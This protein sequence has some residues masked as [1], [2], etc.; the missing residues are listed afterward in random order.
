ML[1]LIIC[2]GYFSKLEP[3][4]LCL[5]R[6]KVF[7]GKH[8]IGDHWENTKYQVIEWQLNLP[9]YTIKPWQVEG[10]TQVVHRNLL[11]HIAHPHKQDE[12]ESE[13]DDS[14][15][16]TSGDI[17]LPDPIQSRMGP[18]TWSQARACQ[19]AQSIWEVWNKAIQCIQHKENTYA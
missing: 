4:D 19:L 13:S 3:R 17:V 8:K 11:M 2:I 14:E 12:T 6:Q 9:V 7:G 10:Q 16:D 15:Y 1:T 5:V 18:M